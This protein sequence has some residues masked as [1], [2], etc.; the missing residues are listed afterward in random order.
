MCHAAKGHVCDG[1]DDTRGGGG[2]FTSKSLA[3]L[4]VCGN[5]YIP[6]FI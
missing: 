2:C 6:L 1:L 4:P 3:N 5:P